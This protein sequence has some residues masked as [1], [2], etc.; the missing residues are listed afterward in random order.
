V[1]RPPG[2]LLV[3][4]PH[5][6]D[7]VLSCGATIA[8]AAD[9]GDDVVVATFFDGCP[10]PEDLTPAGREFHESCGLGADAMAVRTAEDDAALRVLGADA[11]RFG[12]FEGLYRRAPA[13]APLY[14][15]TS[16]FDPPGGPEGA[17]VSQLEGIVASLLKDLEPAAVLYPLGVGG[18]VDHLAVRDATV[19]VSAGFRGPTWLAFEDVPYVLFPWLAGWEARVTARPE[20]WPAPPARWHAKIEAIACYSSQH[21][22]LFLDPD[23]WATDLH[24]YATAVGGGV[25]AERFWT[26]P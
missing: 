17:V 15:G 21:R 9:D 11:R 1:R 20:V 23:T 6:D 12:L 5:L 13:G 2:P 24:A 18:H 10:P 14:S 3:L 16:I 8:A 7:G 19:R 25:P 4:S 22:I 26:Q